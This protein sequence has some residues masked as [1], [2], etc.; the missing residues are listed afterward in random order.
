[1]L[2]PALAFSFV[3]LAFAAC[4][5]PRPP[6]G[7]PPPPTPRVEVG[8]SPTLEPPEPPRE[9]TPAP[10][11]SA[12]A[13]SEMPV[14]APTTRTPP[15]PRFDTDRCEEDDDCAWDDPCEPTRCGTGEPAHDLKCTERRADPGRC[16]CH[17]HMCARKPGADEAT[18]PRGACKSDEQ[19]ALDLGAGRCESMPSARD[20]SRLGPVYQSGPYCDCVDGGCELRWAEPVACK[21]DAECW[22]ERKGGRLKLKRSDKPRRLPFKP[23]R[24]GEVDAVCANGFCQLRAWSC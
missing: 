15:S 5:T 19:C 6:E 23:C 11:M 12:A 16:V 10:S 21:S 9:P 7:P 14:A 1:M 20:V 13:A 3:A 17:Q 2:R 24:D 22:W 8:P 18:K 4:A